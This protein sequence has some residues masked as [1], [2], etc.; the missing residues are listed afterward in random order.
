MQENLNCAG[1]YKITCSGN[2]KFYIGST[3]CFRARFKEHRND[4]RHNRHHSRYLQN[5]CNKYGLES[6]VFEIIEI[7]ED[8][9]TL[10]KQEY[11]YIQNLNPECNF[12]RDIGV[13]F[14]PHD[15]SYCE[16]VAKTCREKAK[17]QIS[18][19]STKTTGVMFSTIKN[20][21]IAYINV[22]NKSTPL[23]SY[24][25]F[26]KAFKARQEGERV[27]W[28]DKYA[29]LSDE[30]RDILDQHNSLRLQQQV[31]NKSALTK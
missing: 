15:R 26:E 29:K 24:L 20:R 12:M 17:T 2:N 23:G 5:C 28:S 4:L 21:F 22:K 3:K 25:T 31:I 9:T 6:L 8:L 11:E 16:R 1:I 18:Q 13:E 19:S 10:L 27:F 30:E 14:K 7:I